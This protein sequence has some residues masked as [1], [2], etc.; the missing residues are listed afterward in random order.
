MKVRLVA[1]S[2][3]RQVFTSIGRMF[4]QIFQKKIECSKELQGSFRPLAN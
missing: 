4:K 3:M 1:Y 2:T